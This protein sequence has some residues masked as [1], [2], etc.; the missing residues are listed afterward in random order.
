MTSH[1]LF[2]DNMQL[3]ETWMCSGLCRQRYCWSCSCCC[4]CQI[5]T[6]VVRPALTGLLL[7]SLL[8]HSLSYFYKHESCEQC[9]PCREGTDTPAA[10][11]AAVFL[12]GCPTSTS[13]SRVGSARHAVK[14]LTHLLLL[15]L[16]LL[17]CLL[18]Q[19][20]LLLQARVMWAVHAM[21]RGH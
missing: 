14:A 6:R 17:L 13:T 16:L 20:V 2:S 11:A 4:A 18:L 7:M 12:P 19:V 10:A 8:Y 9:T 5:V 21:P 1:P 15:L 3:V